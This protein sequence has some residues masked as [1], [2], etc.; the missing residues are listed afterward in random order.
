MKHTKFNAPQIN[1]I[2]HKNYIQL[3]VIHHKLLSVHFKKIIQS[4]FINVVCM[5]SYL[6]LL[7]L[8]TTEDRRKIFSEKNN[9]YK[10]TFWWCNEDVIMCIFSTRWRVMTRNWL[11]RRSGSAVSTRRRRGC[12]TSASAAPR[13][14]PTSNLH[15]RLLLGLFF[16]F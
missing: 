6:L 9:Y 3:H 11:T 5:Q 12:V 4:R 7:Y 1:I 2:L 15:V 10:W 13:P 16:S 8:H 14:S